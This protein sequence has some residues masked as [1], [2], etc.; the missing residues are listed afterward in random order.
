MFTNKQR[1]LD[2]LDEGII[3]VENNS[4]VFVNAVSEKLFSISKDEFCK[5]KLDEFLNDFD[6]VCDFKK[7]INDIKKGYSI[8]QSFHITE[9]IKLDTL[10][11]SVQVMFINLILLFIF[12]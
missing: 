7:A 11:C 12:V 5:L 6:S 3:I 4:I 1:S 9:E 10:K 8:S 2:S